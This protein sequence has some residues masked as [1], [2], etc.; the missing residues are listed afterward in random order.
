MPVCKRSMVGGGMPPTVPA[1]GTSLERSRAPTQISRLP[2]PG[3]LPLHCD[4]PRDQM[5]DDDALNPLP[6]SL[7]NVKKPLHER[8]IDIS[9]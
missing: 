9:D 8:R 1:R 3:P 4:Q 7:R 5:P 2:S 6:L